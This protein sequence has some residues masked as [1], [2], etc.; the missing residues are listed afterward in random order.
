VDHRT[1]WYYLF[2]DSLLQE[3][4]IWRSYIEKWRIWFGFYLKK[5][6]HFGGLKHS[7]IPALPGLDRKKNSPP[8]YCHIAVLQNLKFQLDKFKN[9][10]E[11]AIIK[12]LDR[13][14]YRFC[15]IFNP[16]FFLWTTYCSFWLA[17][18]RNFYCVV[19]FLNI[20]FLFY[21]SFLLQICCF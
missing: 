14:K 6:H 7:P 19:L 8:T 13:T 5:I 3:S 21:F 10:E 17:I 1:H 9:N 18:K 12:T 11:K 4:Q 20:F 16:Y 15:M 2:S